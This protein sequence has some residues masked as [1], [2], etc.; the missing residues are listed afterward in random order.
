MFLSANF[1]V[2]CFMFFLFFF[3]SVGNMMCCHVRFI[4]GSYDGGLLNP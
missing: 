1:R 2:W 4:S 3:W